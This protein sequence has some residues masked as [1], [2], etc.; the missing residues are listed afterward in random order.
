MKIFWTILKLNQ[1]Y[2]YVP[3]FSDL[4]QDYAYQENNIVMYHR[5]SNNLCVCMNKQRIEEKHMQVEHVERSID[6]CV[7]VLIRP[8][9][10]AIVHSN[11]IRK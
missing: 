6:N 10:A 3:R 5:I 9:V 1:F 11:C 7:Q 8:L 2:M 4:E